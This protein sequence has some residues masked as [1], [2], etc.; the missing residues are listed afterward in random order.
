MAW[1]PEHIDF[2]S[3]YCDRWCERC[4]LTH[5]CA[6]F[7]RESDP[8]EIAAHTQAVEKSMEALRVE[9][10]LPEP[11]TPAW[12]EEVLSAPPPTEAEQKELTREYDSRC[13]RVR[14]D[15]MMVVALDYAVDAYTWVK[16]YADMTRAR[17]IAARGDGRDS[18]EAAVVRMEVDGVLDAL[19]VVR[20]DST[21]IAAKLRRAMNGKEDRAES[22]EDDPAQTDWNGSAK[23]TLILT[24]RS[25]AGWRLIARWAPE[26][27]IAT[28]MANTLAALRRDIERA[29]P[30][31]R[32]FIRPGFDEMP[33]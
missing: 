11:S 32:R 7:T 12:L 15:P 3:E 19:E 5:K 1:D 22:F 29:F 9:L 4:P 8:E 14:N 28:Q 21:L 10:A 2:I 13:D 6:A 33:S 16:L 23:L 31:A 27:E 17:A 26:S 18:A 30:L 24:E 25:E 20:W